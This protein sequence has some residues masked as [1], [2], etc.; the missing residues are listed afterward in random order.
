MNIEW[1][2][3]TGHG[4]DCDTHDSINLVYGDPWIAGKSCM[5]PLCSPQSVG[6]GNKACSAY[7][8]YMPVH[9]VIYSTVA[10]LKNDPSSSTGS[11]LRS[12]YIMHVLLPG[13]FQ[14]KVVASFVSS[15]YWIALHWVKTVVLNLL[16]LLRNGH[17]MGTNRWNIIC[18]YLK[19]HWQHDRSCSPCMPLFSTTIRCSG[20]LP[21]LSTMLFNRHGSPER[22]FSW[23]PPQSEA[24]TVDKDRSTE[25]VF[26]RKT[27]HNSVPYPLRQL[28]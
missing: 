27:H 1:I 9:D 19:E 25:P 11:V 14:S 6:S 16:W 15:V 22:G 12:W 5:C 4:T 18:D 10:N 3:A 2:K 28:P 20:L 13:G 7:A 21:S 8:H 26:E 24:C 17:N 23:K